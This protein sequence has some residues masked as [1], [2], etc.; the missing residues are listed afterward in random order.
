MF[1][2]PTKYNQQGI[3]C[4]CVLFLKRLTAN[5]QLTWTPGCLSTI[6][7]FCIIT[8]VRSDISFNLKPCSLPRLWSKP[9]TF[10]IPFLTS[11]PP[12]L[13]A[14]IPLRNQHWYFYVYSERWQIVFFNNNCILSK[15]N[16]LQIFSLIYVLSHCFIRSVIFRYPIN[17]RIKPYCFQCKS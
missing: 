10:Q 8:S 15:K 5:T 2:L 7:R 3:Q 17:W 16:A 12:K 13:K 9:K 4:K 14:F 11:S 6:N 1:W